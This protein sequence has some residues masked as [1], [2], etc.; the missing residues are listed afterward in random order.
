MRLGSSDVG[1]DVKDNVQKY[2]YTKRFQ[3]GYVVS[4]VLEIQNIDTAHVLIPPMVRIWH[5]LIR[6]FGITD[7]LT[8]V[9]LRFILPPLFYKGTLN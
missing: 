4:D 5:L 7:D 8:S 9:F 6:R 2:R 3:I 1:A